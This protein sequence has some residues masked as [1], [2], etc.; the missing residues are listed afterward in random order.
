[1]EFE[2]HSSEEYASGLAFRRSFSVIG[3]PETAE[4][5]ARMMHNL[6]RQGCASCHVRVI[7]PII[8]TPKP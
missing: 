6:V 2:I 8:V 5:H 3:S 1:M 7:G 4:Y